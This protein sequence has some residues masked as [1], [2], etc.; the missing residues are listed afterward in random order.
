MREVAARKSPVPNWYLDLSLL[1]AYWDG[2][3]RAYHHTAPINMIYGLDAALTVV[4][5][6][7]RDA[8]FQRHLDAHQYLVSELEALGLSLYV[9][10]E[11]RLPMLNAVSIPDG[12]DDAGVRS[13][14]LT[15][16]AIEIGAGLGPL[17]GKIWRVG[18]MGH[19][20]R[21]E[22]VDKLVQAFREEL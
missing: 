15:R 6:E 13:A 12:A 14:L 8:V 20:A 10:R 11:A 7:G 21:R 22:N 1:S 16:H 5:E 19:S 17:A 3:K 4:L 18:L 2:A 9:P